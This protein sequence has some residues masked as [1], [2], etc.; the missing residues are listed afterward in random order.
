[1]TD[2]TKLTDLK[3]IKQATDPEASLHD[4]VMKIVVEQRANPPKPP[5]PEPRPTAESHPHFSPHGLKQAQAAWD[6]Q[7]EIRRISAEWAAEKAK[8]REAKAKDAEAL[9]AKLAA[10]QEARLLEPARLAFLATGA[11]EAD[12]L[13]QRDRIA[14][15]IRTRRAVEA[16]IAN[17]IR[18]LIPSSAA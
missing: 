7:R 8:E 2:T 11:S 13:E 17:P 5:T 9:R 18:S 6:E 12:W 1:M 14:R 16:G 4:R 15:E 3:Q 10:E